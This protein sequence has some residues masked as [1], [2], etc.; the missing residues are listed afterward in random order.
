MPQSQHPAPSTL[1]SDCDAYTAA[2]VT[3]RAMLAVHGPGAIGMHDFQ[4]AWQTC[5]DCKNRHGGMQPKQFSPN[6]VKP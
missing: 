2:Q 4:M 5:E 1:A 3:M 6:G